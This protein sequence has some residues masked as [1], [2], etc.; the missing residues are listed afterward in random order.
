MAG[1]AA[2]NRGVMIAISAPGLSNSLP[3]SRLKYLTRLG[4]TG[5]KLPIFKEIARLGSPARLRV[6]LPC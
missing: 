1:A 6:G 5:V 4:W 3:G 2:E